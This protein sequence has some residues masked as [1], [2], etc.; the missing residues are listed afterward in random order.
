MGIE[1]IGNSHPVSVFGCTICHG[2]NPD[3]LNKREA[4]KGLIGG[5][6]PSDFRFVERSCGRTAPNGEPCHSVK[7][8]WF[9]NHIKRA[10]NSLMSTMAG[11]IHGIL[12]HWKAKNTGPFS[13]IENRHL[14]ML[15]EVKIEPS[16]ATN[17]ELAIDH[18][19]KLC[20]KCHT[21]V[22]AKSGT[23]SH[24]SGCAACHT[25]YNDR[26][27]YDGLD[28]TI[29]RD[30]FGHPSKHV[31][32]TVIPSR[33]CLHCHNRSGREGT[34]YVGLME[35]AFYGTPYV[36]GTFGAPYLM[37]GRYMY[38]MVPDIHYEKGMHCIDCH[39]S[40]E[41]MGTGEVHTKMYQQLEIRCE[42]CHGTYTSP[43]KG[44]KVKEGSLAEF[45][46]TF[47]PNYSV[48]PGDTVGVTSRGTPIPNLKLEKG[49]WYLYSKVTGKRYKVPV[50][51]GN[52]RHNFRCQDKLECYSCHSRWAPMCYGCHDILRSGSQY[53]YIA[54][55]RKRG[56]WIERRGFIRFFPF[57]L[58]VNHRGKVSPM[59]FCQSEVFIEANGTVRKG[60]KA[61]VAAAINP[62][63]TRRVGLT[64]RQ[65]HR[66][67]VIM[68]LGSGIYNSTASGIGYPYSPETVVK[69]G[70]T[71]METEPPGTRGLNTKE[72]ERMLKAPIR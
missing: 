15:P 32:T 52:P 8:P 37:G 55:K 2:G 9:K 35:S 60:P 10:R 20:A 18:F 46:A 6:N 42:D 33:H 53:D 48:E 47:N 38:R 23:S 68:G 39:T 70:K 45:T 28:P 44:M 59:I 13:A 58:G 7:V 49:K 17:F 43:P 64:C 66:N 63:T 62:H 40:T 54:K 5:K 36:N 19:R 67:R 30:Q 12:K 57:V 1:D 51:T 21:G 25:P 31:L 71:I 56:R 27:T 34:S 69:N 65:C 11:V 26:G 72:I 4:H 61:F 16:K 24:A 3:T 22:E 14:P 50:I 29:P 41:I